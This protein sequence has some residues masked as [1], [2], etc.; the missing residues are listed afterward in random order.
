MLIAKE[1]SNSGLRGLLGA[2]RR[3][4]VDDQVDAVPG[5]AFGEELSEVRGPAGDDPNPTIAV[6]GTARAVGHVF[7]PLSGPTAAGI[8]RW[9]QMA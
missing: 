9:L 5:Q 8:R 1:L 2:L 6:A 4:V 3:L 7:P